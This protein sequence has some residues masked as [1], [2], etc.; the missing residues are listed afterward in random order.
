MG[1][2]NWG[3]RSYAL[4][5]LCVTTAIALQAQ[6]VTRLHSFNGAMS[7]SVSYGALVQ[8]TNGDGQSDTPADPSTPAPTTAPSEAKP[9]AGPEDGGR[10]GV[11][12]KTR[13]A[14]FEGEAEMLIVWDRRKRL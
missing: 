3:K 12:I 9:G 7:G 1:K 4:L 5:L 8:A 11:G 14:D 13:H 6:T 2:L 10:I